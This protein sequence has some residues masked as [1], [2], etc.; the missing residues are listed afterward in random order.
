MD[1]ECKFLATCGFFK[2]YQASKQLACRGFIR[3]YCR[4]PK[5]D[6]CK[7]KLYRAEHGSSPPDDMMPTGHMMSH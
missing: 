4:G 6:E 2:K 1:I 5:K 7:R 3:Q